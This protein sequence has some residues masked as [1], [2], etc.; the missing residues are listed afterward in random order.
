MRQTDKNWYEILLATAEGGNAKEKAAYIRDRFVAEFAWQID[1]YGQQRAAKEW[2]QGLALS[3]PYM[4]YSI[5]ELA[6]KW[7]WTAKED[8]ILSRYWD[9]LAAKMLKLIAIK[10]NS[11]L[12]KELN[13]D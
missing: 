11:K 6:K 1:R 10:G 2:L 7:G 12:W 8:Y 9:I 3:V 13:N 4:N 5:L